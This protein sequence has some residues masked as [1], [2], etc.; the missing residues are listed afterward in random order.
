MKICLFTIC[1]QEHGD[2]CELE[3]NRRAI[4]I[5]YLDSVR[6]LEPATART[7]AYRVT[8]LAYFDYVR[9][10]GFSRVHIWSCPPQRQLGFVFWCRPVSKDPEC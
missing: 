2:N 8:L 6:Y 4:Y 7:L 10:H 5:A 9:R 3:A 1:A